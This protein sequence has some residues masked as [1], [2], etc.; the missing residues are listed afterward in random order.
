MTG[1]GWFGLSNGERC[2]CH[3]AAF[4]WAAGGR[5]GSALGKWELPLCHSQ[6]LSPPLELRQKSKWQRLVL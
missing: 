6:H 5:A 3:R 4:P 2:R 1:R